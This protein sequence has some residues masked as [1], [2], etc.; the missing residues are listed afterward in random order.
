M[1][2]VICYRRTDGTRRVLVEEA[3][4]DR[5]ELWAAWPETVPVPYAAKRYET[6]SVARRHARASSEWN[7][8]VAVVR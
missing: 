5:A 1:P 8:L 6:R 4:K 7:Y 3:A 2:W